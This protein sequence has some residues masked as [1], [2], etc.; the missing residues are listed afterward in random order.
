[1]PVRTPPPE[2][3]EE[4]LIAAKMQDLFRESCIQFPHPI[5]V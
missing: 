1:M 3:R 2:A 5:A 4:T